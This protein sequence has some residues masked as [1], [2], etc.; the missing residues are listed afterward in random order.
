MKLFSRSSVLLSAVAGAAMLVACGTPRMDQE[1][2]VT[3]NEAMKLPMF[4]SAATGKILVVAL[5]DNPCN[6]GHQMPLIPVGHYSA[7]KAG[8]LFGGFG[9][10]ASKKNGLVERIISTT[11]VMGN[12]G[13]VVELSTHNYATGLVKPV[14]GGAMP[15]VD[16]LQNINWPM[17]GGKIVNTVT[18]PD[19]CLLTI[20]KERNANTVFGFEILELSAKRAK[21]HY[22]VSDVA[23]GIVKAEGTYL[24]KEGV[25]FDANFVQVPDATK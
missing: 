6:R 21:I 4:K 8:G 3:L 18:G 2:K 13:Q 11:L 22:R 17:D 20:A 14:Q 16:V 19:L 5:N 24:S 15:V 23:S 7:P 9:G 12:I 25:P 1:V 10:G